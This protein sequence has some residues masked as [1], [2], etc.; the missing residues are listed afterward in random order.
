[1]ASLRSALGH[2]LNARLSGLEIGQTVEARFFNNS[3]VI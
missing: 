1:M 3:E 2:S